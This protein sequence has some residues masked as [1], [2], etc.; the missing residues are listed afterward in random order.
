M[1]SRIQLLLEDEFLDRVITPIER[2]MTEKMTEEKITIAKTNTYPIIKKAIDEFCTENNLER[3]D[4]IKYIKD[5][6]EKRLKD[7]NNKFKC[8]YRLVREMIDTIPDEQKTAGN[9]GV[10][11]IKVVL[12][13]RMRQKTTH[14]FV[15]CADGHSPADRVC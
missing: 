4:V 2:Y 9:F 6:I 15:E 14:F 11:T 12:S 3:E 13:A 5:Y 7:E 1:D 10:L 8:K